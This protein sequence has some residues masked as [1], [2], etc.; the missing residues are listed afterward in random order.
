MTSRFEGRQT[1][2]LAMAV[3]L[4]AA[5]CS[6]PQPPQVAASDTPVATVASTPAPSEQ[7][8]AAVAAS[9]SV[10]PATDSS[11]CHPSP[12]Q[13]DI[14]IS[15]PTGLGTTTLH[16]APGVSCP[17]KLEPAQAVPQVAPARA[18]Q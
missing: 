2:A 12:P 7:P 1:A 9:G 16:G 14:Q 18:A 15:N 3:L 4:A 17:P 11:D 10:T 13:P 5:A 8:S 6:R